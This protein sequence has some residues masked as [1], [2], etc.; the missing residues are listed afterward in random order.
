M[1]QHGA[2]WVPAAV[3]KLMGSLA[4]GQ[5][6]AQSGET[7]TVRTQ[8]MFYQGKLKDSGVPEV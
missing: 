5:V 6:E 3:F 1:L 2:V 4:D 8:M 7:E